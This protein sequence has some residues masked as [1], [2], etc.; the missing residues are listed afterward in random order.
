LLPS[1]NGTTLGAL[2]A[3]TPAT[4]FQHYEFKGSY[5]LPN[6]ASDP[7]NNAI[8]HS[9]EEFDDLNVVVW[10]QNTATKEVLQSAWATKVAGLSEEPSG[11]GIIE[12]FPNPANNQANVRYLLNENQNVNI[13]VYNILGELVYSK[14]NGTQSAGIHTSTI[15]TNEISEGLYIVKLTIG[16]NVY[17]QKLNIN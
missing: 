15:N 13:Q 14:N 2:T 17:T 11:N 8:E 5:R 9:V 7:I 12:L 6:N 16:N 3:G 1:A 10:V 4:D